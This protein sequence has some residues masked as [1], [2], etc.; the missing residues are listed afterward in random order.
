VGAQPSMEVV[1]QGRSV[2]VAD[3]RRGQNGA[4]SHQDLDDPMQV[5]RWKV[6]MTQ[7]TCQVAAKMFHVCKAGVTN[8]MV[9]RVR[10]R[11]QRVASMSVLQE[12]LMT[13]APP[14]TAA[15]EASAKVPWGDLQRDKLIDR[16]ASPAFCAVPLTRSLRWHFR[17]IAHGAV[18]TS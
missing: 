1:A 17:A 4:T 13:S 2:E 12:P 5:P 3:H 18:L 11:A 7:R 16:R 10:T 6:W 14:C 8:H 15:G 9:A